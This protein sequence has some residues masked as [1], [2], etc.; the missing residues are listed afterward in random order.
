MKRIASI[1]LLAIFLFN[2]VGYRLLSDY[3]QHRADAALESRLDQDNYDESQLVEMRIPLNMPYLNN[4]SEFE[5][6]DGEAEVNGVLYKYVKRKIDNGQLVILCLPNQAKT[7]LLSARDDF[8][9]L[10]NDLQQTSQNKKSGNTV[11]PQNPITE[12]TSQKNDF[13]LLEWASSFPQYSSKD[14]ELFISPAL[15]EQGQPPEC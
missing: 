11:A 10:V 9:K 1:L 4:Q 2:W 5:R 7:K 3:L 15:S 14:T 13:A 12:Y 6:F 8:F